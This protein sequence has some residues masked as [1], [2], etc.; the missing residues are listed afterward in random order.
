MRTRSWLPTIVTLG[1]LTLALAPPAGAGVAEDLAA[2][3]QATLKYR[4]VARAV[5]AGYEQTSACTADGT[6][7]AMGFH[8]ISRTL[9][10]DGIFDPRKPEEL[11]YIPH[12]SGKGLKLAGVEFHKDDADQNLATNDDRPMLFERP[13]DGPMP[14]HG[15][16]EPIHYD[17]HVWVHV[18]N[19]DGMFAMFNPAASCVLALQT[20]SAPR[21]MRGRPALLGGV[22]VKIKVGR[23][24]SRI[25]ATLRLGRTVLGRAKL[26]AKEVGRERL[27]VK[28]KRGL[29]VLHRA[30]AASARV[31]LRLQVDSIQVG[32]FHEKR[33][34]RVTLRRPRG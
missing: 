30:L 18:R 13:F 11:L 33:M 10:N 15:P 24:D 29:D 12:P 31:R 28:L 9:V 17:L 1:A 23:A 27:V 21:I 16:G 19:P 20:V 22:P 2:A 26:T 34:L 25:S 6:G 32:G 5:D 8:F 14:G 7:A 3:K 4:D